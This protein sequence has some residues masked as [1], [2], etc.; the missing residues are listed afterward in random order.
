MGEVDVVIA[1]EFAVAVAAAAAE[2]AV[3]DMEAMEAMED[4][5]AMAL[6]EVGADEDE[7]ELTI[8]PIPQGMASLSGA[9]WVEFVG[10]TTVTPSAAV[11]VKRV[12]QA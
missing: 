1:V 12:A 5:E 6:D 11:M 7:A 8:V 4:M 10:G 3:M 9:G 2:V